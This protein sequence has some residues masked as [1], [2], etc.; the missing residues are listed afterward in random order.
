MFNST[1]QHARILATYVVV[2]K[3]AVMWLKNSDT[4]DGGRYDTFI[5][6]LLGGYLVF[7]SEPGGIN[8]QVN[9]ILPP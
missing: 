4:G 3:L 8:Q 7:G 9:H 5:A 6:G 1:K 2:Y